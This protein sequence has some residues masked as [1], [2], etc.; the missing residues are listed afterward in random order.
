MP[1]KINFVAIALD[2]YRKV[3]AMGVEHDKARDYAIDSVGL[4]GSEQTALDEEIAIDAVRDG[5]ER[6][7]GIGSWDCDA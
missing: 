4:S 6:E 2:T 1:Q 3:T 5:A 7:R